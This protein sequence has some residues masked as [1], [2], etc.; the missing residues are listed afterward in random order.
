MLA[1]A[2]AIG[3]GLRLTLLYRVP[4]LFMPGDSQSFLLPAFDLARGVGFE[5]VLKRPPGYP[6]LVAGAL[7]LL[8]EDLH[9]LVFLQAG[10]GLGTVA[11]SYWIGRLAYGRVPGLLAALAA[12][13]GGQLLIYEHYILAESAFTLLLALGVLGALAA[14]SVRPAFAVLGGLAIG[15]ATLLRPIAEGLIPLWPFLFLATG[16]RRRALALSGWLLLGFLVVLAPASL[17]ELS[18]QG[19]SSS[20]AL[21][22]VL[23]WRI[24]R[25][26]SGYLGR[27][28]AARADSVS[29]ARRYVIRRAAE[30]TLPQEIYDGVRR[31]Y[32]LSPAEADALLRDVALEAVL[33]QPGWY[34]ASTVRMSIELFLADDQRL[35]DISKRDGEV[36]YSNPQA[37]QRTW[38]EERI[39]HLA[40]PPPATVQNE[41]ERAEALISLY[42]PGRYGAA[43]ACLFLV[44]LALAAFGRPNRLGLIPAACVL[45]MLVANS[46]LS[47]PEP[48]F[49]YPLDPLIGVVASGGLAGA[50]GLGLIGARRLATSGRGESSPDERKLAPAS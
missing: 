36:R 7:R 30:R 45:A 3:L 9:G 31:E 25:A 4:P 32:D 18:R 19:G 14:L 21:G 13:I 34:L 46:A 10:L 48:R 50:L 5:P 43:I 44:G 22:E 15:A 6:L 47:G 38:F 16:A 20:G 1:I 37:K 23:L 26:D 33:R 8:G 17:F 49:R 28:D 12:A 11:A 27:D 39:L 29:A 42:Q 2:L 41:F 24:T 35:G 40:E